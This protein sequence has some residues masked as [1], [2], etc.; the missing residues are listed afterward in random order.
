MEITGREENGEGIRHRVK[1]E[2]EGGNTNEMKAVIDHKGE[3]EIMQSTPV[4]LI[5]GNSYSLG[6][7]FVRN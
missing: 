5:D 1:V 3:D 4:T 7:N 6:E 2:E